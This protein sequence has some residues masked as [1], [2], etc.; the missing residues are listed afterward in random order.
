MRDNA[1]TDPYQETTPEIVLEYVK[2]SVEDEV[3]V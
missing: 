2:A 1:E 3:T